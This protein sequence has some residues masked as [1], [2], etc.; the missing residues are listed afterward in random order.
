MRLHLT[1]LAHAVPV[2]FKAGLLID[3]LNT[4]GIFGPPDASSQV[5][6]ELAAES[7]RRRT[8]AEA[9]EA[10]RRHVDAELVRSRQGGWRRLLPSQHS[11]RYAQFVAAARREIHALPYQLSN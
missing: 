1:M 10:A 8:P 4:V 9:H 7:T 11:G 5:T 2:R 6:H 3:L